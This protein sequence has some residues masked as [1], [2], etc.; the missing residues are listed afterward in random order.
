MLVIEGDRV[1]YRPT[2]YVA[3]GDDN[4]KYGQ[5][6]IVDCIEPKILIQRLQ[7][8]Y[9]PGFAAYIAYKRAFNTIQDIVEVGAVTGKNKPLLV[10]T[11]QDH[12]FGSKGRICAKEQ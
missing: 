10:K 1:I 2:K 7:C 8:R 3:T 9:S 11:E 6:V 4:S 12:L 5:A